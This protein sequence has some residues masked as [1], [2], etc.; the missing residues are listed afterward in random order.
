[1]MN[2]LLVIAGIIGLLLFVRWVRKQPRKKQAQ[3][4]LILVAVIF[5]AMALTGRLHW[6]FALIAAA[7]AFIQKMI[8]FL[9]YIPLFGAIYSKLSGANRDSDQSYTHQNRSNES[10]NERSTHQKPI[11]N[12]SMTEEQAYNILGL[13]NTAT[14]EDIIDAHRRLMQ[15]IHPDRGGT[16]FLASQ[17]NQAK[18]LLLKKTA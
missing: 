6:L 18:D 3:A 7:A 15:K 8:P 5:V 1:M 13:E 12:R 14:Q 10:N 16:D 2:Q 9:R 17:I 11:H 4:V